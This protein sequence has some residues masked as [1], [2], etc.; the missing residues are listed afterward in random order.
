MSTLKEFGFAKDFDS[1]FH[2]GRT[3][4]SGT[5]GTVHIAV[6]RSTGQ[7]YAVKV[8]TKRIMGGYLEQHFVRRVRHE[9]DIYNHVGRSLNVAYMYGAYENAVQVQLVMELCTGGELWTRVQ[10]GKYDEGA[11]AALAREILRTVA[12]CHA[13]DIVLRDVKPENFLFL[14]PAADAPLKMIDFGLATYCRPGEV[15]KDRAGSPLYVAPEVLKQ[16]YGQK[17]DVWSAGVIAYQL[18][19]GRFPFEDEDRGLLLSSLDVLGKRHFSNKEVFFSI[20]YNDLDFERPPWDSISPLAKD[21]VKSL[22]QRDVS[23]RPTAAEALQHPW[24]AQ[25]DAA[26]AS[27][28]AAS[29]GPEAQQGQGQAAVSPRPLSDSLVQ[30]LQR[31][32]TYGRLKQLALRAVASYMAT[33][34]PERVASLA[35]AFRQLDPHGAGRV[36]YAAVVQMLNSGEWDLSAT[37]VAQLLATFDVDSGGNVDYDEWLAALIDWREV[38]E[39]AEW[40]DYVNKVFD[41]FDSSH[42][43]NLTPEALQRLLCSGQL[44]PASSSSSSSSDNDAADGGGDEDAAGRELEECPFDDVV[45]AALR[46]VNQA[47]NGFIS[48][49]DFERLLR[50]AAVDRLEFYEDRRRRRR[51]EAGAGA[52]A[53]AAGT[54][55]AAAGDATGMQG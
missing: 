16:A 25:A 14:T 24:L 10:R 18:L 1:R 40:Q 8:I 52:G 20:L 43:G 2:L 54:V 39:S 46:E 3:V 6:N 41:M 5:F 28:V 7:E 11:A 48:R 44:P 49:E 42:T 17:C 31:Y 35:A 4:G 30:R 13:K 21:F 9:V 33:S 12:Q 45:P 36:P 38:Q 53:D 27:A 34:E 51:S 19:T 15:L 47:P 22:L 26:V 23:A 32:G 50:T 29:A 55:T 37:E